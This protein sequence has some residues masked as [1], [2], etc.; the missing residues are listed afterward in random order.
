MERADERGTGDPPV[1]WFGTG[2]S[3]A[4]NSFAS[5]VEAARSAV[6][7][8]DAKLVLV[9]A[10]MV[11]DFDRLLAGIR[12]VTGETP[13]IGCSTAGEISSDAAGTLGVSITILGGSFDIEVVASPIDNDLFAAASRAAE[14]GEAVVD[15]E[16]RVLLMLSDGLAGDQQ[17]V[18][19]GA[20]ATLGVTVPLV[21]GC[22]GDDLAM[23]RTYQFLNGEVLQ[24]SIVAASIASDAPLGI[25][26]RHGWRSVGEA[27]VVTQ[28][29]GP[30]V[31]ELD[32]TAALDAYGTRLNLGPEILKNSGAFTDFALTHPLG[33]QHHGLEEVRFVTGAD[34]VDG[35]IFCNAEIPQGGLVW[36]M[37]GDHDSV[38][39]GTAESI[40][41]ALA[42]LD[43]ADP[44]G[45]LAFDCVARRKVLGDDK[46]QQ[47]L[48]LIAGGA[49]GA[50][51]SGFYTYGEFART[52]G[53]RG[54]HNQTLVTL[55]IA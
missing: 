5:G 20:Y 15:R 25:G 30:I 47:E 46:L 24:D 31:S 21:G 8:E 36:I 33:I 11:H 42:P 1:R 17:E 4:A 39:A 40:Q 6:Q 23:T 54:F 44:I 49:N 48:G 2:S 51:V 35:S 41:D 19:R 43:G 14:C 37:E 7:G 34:V 52:G 9:F 29:L 3:R 45:I 27:M 18:V 16:H 13:L 12:S 22:A 53:S 38:L 10:S 28:S 26:A 32:G 55:A 50:P